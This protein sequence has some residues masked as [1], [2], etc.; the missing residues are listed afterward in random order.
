M[1][2]ENN[3]IQLTKEQDLQKA[4]KTSN[5]AIALIY[6]SWCPFCT[7][8]LPVFKKCIEK[9]KRPVLLVQDD[10][11]NVATKY[12]IK[13][14]PTVLFFEKGNIAK[15]LDGAPG[16]GLQENQLVEFIDSCPKPD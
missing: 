10:D 5:N 9:D 4:L 2:S 3:F 6:A 16:V 1:T 8:F 12:G 13:I 11:E 7:K 14:F 15:R